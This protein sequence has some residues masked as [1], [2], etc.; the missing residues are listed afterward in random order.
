MSKEPRV[1][2]RLDTERRGER[3]QILILF[4]LAVIVIVGM[5]GLVL[6]G[7][8]AYAQRRAEQSVADLSAMAGA[9]AYLSAPGAASA[10]AAAA[11]LAARG[12]AAANG[13]SHTVSG[14]AVDVTIA[15]ITGGANVTVDLT[16]KHANNFA[17]LLGMSTWDVSVTATAQT[18]NTPNAAIGVMPL[19]FNAEAFPGAICDETAGGCV[20]EVYQLPG[21]G[22]EDVPQD[23]TQFNWTVFCA[24]D[25]GTECNASSD[26]V[27]TIMGWGGNATVISVNDDIGPLNAGTHSDLL[28]S[29]GSSSA[30]AL[31]DHIGEMFPV[32]I[33]TDEGNMVG[34]AYFKLLSIEGSPDRVIRGYFVSPV[35]A[36]QLIV[37][38]TGGTPGLQTGAYTLKLID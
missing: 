32:P 37:S 26:D 20:A 13:Y 18:S 6:D 33:V 8:A 12:I 2:R 15:P 10:K 29:N 16:A 22:S 11:E 30:P 38:P 34:F 14:T 5:L 3:G 27:S 25:S 9:T 17:S 1:M 31:E 24:G 21:T 36:T 19:L 28:L 4:V 23:A 7:G 35:N